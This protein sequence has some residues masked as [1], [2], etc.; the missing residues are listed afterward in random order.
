MGMLSPGKVLDK[1]LIIGINSVT[2]N[3]DHLLKVV[4]DFQKKFL[5]S[6]HVL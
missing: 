6:S 1:L 5:F 4:G 2:D 3:N